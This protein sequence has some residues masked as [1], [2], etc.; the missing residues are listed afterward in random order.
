MN[1]NRILLI[2]FGFLLT[3]EQGFTVV[4]GTLSTGVARGADVV[5]PVDLVIYLLFFV[6]LN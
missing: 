1:I 5:M 2:A 4:L 3:I 6:Y